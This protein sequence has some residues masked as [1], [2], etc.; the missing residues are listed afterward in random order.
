MIKIEQ[1]QIRLRE[2]IRLSGLSQK[3]I[4]IQL[5]ISPSTVSKYVRLN[6]FPSI[7]T[8]ANLCRILDVSADSI[9]CLSDF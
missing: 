1:I 2:A 9:L 7:E 6:K 8:F 5:G 3:D 4:A